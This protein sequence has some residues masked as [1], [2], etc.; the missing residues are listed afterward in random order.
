MNRRG[1]IG[2]S[3]LMLTVIG[4]GVGLGV[5]KYGSIQDQAAASANQ[6]EP[7]DRKSVV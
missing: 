4:V 6:P 3:L 2:S 5:W 1:W 7:I